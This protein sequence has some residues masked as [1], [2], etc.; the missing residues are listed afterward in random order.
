MAEYKVVQFRRGNTA[1]TEVFTGAPG[2]ITVNT[3][4]W[5]A[6]VHDG[7]TPGGHPL[8]V[9]ATEYP[10]QRYLMF[11]AAAVQQGVASLGF[12]SP[13]NA[14]PLPQ[15]IIDDESGLITG[16]ASFSHGTNQSIQDHFLLPENWSN[17]I[18]L[19]IIWRA[20]TTIGSAIWFLETC[21]V[22]LGTILEEN[23]FGTPQSVTTI[24]QDPQYAL[25]TSTIVMDTSN[26]GPTGEVFF[27]LTRDGGDDTIPAPIELISLRFT[28][29]IMEK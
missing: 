28:V 11:R 10:R 27:R 25:T 5:A 22:P 13:L 2:E 19:D 17:P 6:I 18:Q 21:C 26:F 7:R 8:K 24:V 3:D 20:N 1:Q 23:I 4:T 9:E 14:G 29:T 15:A 16:V 12:S